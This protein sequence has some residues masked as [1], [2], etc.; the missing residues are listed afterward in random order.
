MTTSATRTQYPHIMC[1]VPDIKFEKLIKCYNYRWREKYVY[2]IHSI[3]Y[4]SLRNKKAFNGYVNLDSQLLIKLLGTK[5]YKYVLNQLMNSGIVE[6][7]KNANG[8]EIYSKGAFSKSY[9]IAEKYTT[10]TRIKAVPIHKQTYCRKIALAREQAM[11]DAF[12]VNPLLQH[13]FLQ[14]TRRRIDVERATIYIGQT[15]EQGSKQFNARV[16]AIREFDAMK[17]ATFT[18]GKT[19]IGFHFSYNKGR[20]YSPASMLPRDLEQF[21]YFEGEYENERSVNVDMPNS[22]LCFFNE[23]VK[24]EYIGNNL[25]EEEK[26]NKKHP[27]KYSFSDKNNS[28]SLSSHHSIY[29]HT[30]TPYVFPFEQTH[31]TWED[32]I[33]NGL[34]Y[35]RM[36]KLCKWKDK[37]EGHTKQER[38]EFKAE[39]FGQLF[40]NKYSDVFTDMEQVFMFYHE[41]EARALREIKKKLGNKLLAV[42]VQSLEGKFFHHIAVDYMKT[43]YI[44]VPFTIKHDSITLPESCASFILPELNNL[45]REFFKRSDIELKAELL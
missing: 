1:F 21:T 22:Q 37:S 14:M 28:Q 8:K 26:E 9:R 38:Q 16:M 45:V 43:N 42:Q 32:Y 25:Y 34:G 24:R 20:V 3:L 40:Y 6:S 44:D 5:Y 11:K 13:E 7:L 19:N 12:K 15:Y 2:L 29:H 31:R 41:N 35:E 33:F 23:L 30:T 39:F 27:P 10:G 18:Q 17:D 4:P 36:M